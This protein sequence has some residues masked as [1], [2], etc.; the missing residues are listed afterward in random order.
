MIRYWLPI[1]LVLITG[2]YWLFADLYSLWPGLNAAAIMA[3]VFFLAVVVYAFQAPFTRKARIF[4][5]I[6]SII[7]ITL[8]IVGWVNFKATT[9]W[10]RT[11]L[12]TIL[13]RVADGAMQAELSDISMNLLRTH[14]SQFNTSK[15]PIANTFAKLYPNIREGMRIERQHSADSLHIYCSVLQPERIELIARYSYVNGKDLTF[16]NYDGRIGK[17]Q[18]RTVVTE[19]GVTYEYQN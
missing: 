17:K 10:Q 14:H 6:I 9:D 18:T 8:T 4:I 1:G 15:N 16:K 19:K 3:L 13:G 7:I 12:L 2:A 5:S 11:Q